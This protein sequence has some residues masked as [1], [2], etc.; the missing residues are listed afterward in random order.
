MSERVDELVKGILEGQ[1]RAVA[2]AIRLIDDRVKG[3]RELCARLFP[4]TGRAYV[5]G[6][7]GSPGSGKSSLVDALVGYYRKHDLRVGVV[8]VDPS[9][10]YSGGAILGDRIRMQRHFLDEGVFIRSIATRGTLGGLSQS[11]TEVTRVL[12]AYGCDVVIVETV[13]VGQ[14]E[15]DIAGVAH[16][17]V[18]VTAPGL[19]DDIQAVKAGILEIADVFVVNKAD[20]A[21]ADAAVAD[22]EHMIGLG[23]ETMSVDVSGHGHGHGLPPQPLDAASEDTWTPQV[24][25]TCA[26]QG[27]GIEALAD[28]CQQH[29]Q[30]LKE[31][32]QGQAQQAIRLERECLGV[33]RETVLIHAQNVLGQALEAGLERVRTFQEDPYTVAERLAQMA[34][35]D[36]I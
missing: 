24:I 15:L 7:T 12:D 35:G 8:A 22:L 16:T 21:G 31:T 10:P 36:N 1:Q 13:G 11:A 26:T 32:G 6:V 2:R 19:G 4:H 17:T 28:A 25:K 29:R 33:F 3:Y 5:L 14:D 23:K 20:R 9:S 34:S 30:Y 27:M 18:V